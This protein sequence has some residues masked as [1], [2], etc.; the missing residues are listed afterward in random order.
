MH[1]CVEDT[2]QLPLPLQK[3]VGWNVV[4]VQNGAAQPMLAGACVHAPAVHVPVL[5]Q[6]GLTAHKPCGSAAPFETVAHVPLPL[7]LQAWHV[8][9]DEVVQHAPSTQLPVPHSLPA[10]QVAPAAFLATHIE[11][12]LQ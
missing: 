2:E 3:A 5:P 10:P 7:M 6:G 12:A 9:H 1:S 4:P 11:L 8:P